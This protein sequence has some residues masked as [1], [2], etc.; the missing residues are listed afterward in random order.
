MSIRSLLH[1]AG[2]V[3]AEY[4]KICLHLYLDIAWFGVLAASAISFVSVYATHQGQI[5]SRSGC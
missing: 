4:R 5:L 2:Q 1:P 3:P